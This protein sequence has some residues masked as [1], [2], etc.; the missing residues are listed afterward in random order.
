VAIHD[1]DPQQQFVS[2]DKLPDPR[3]DQEKTNSLLSSYNHDSPDIAYAERLAEELVNLSGA[4]ITVYQRTQNEGNKDE[5]WDEDADPTYR[6]GK[7]I[8][9]FFEPAPADI[10]LTR[11]GVDIQNQTTVH[12]SRANIFQTFGKRMISEGDVLIV[13]HN[14]MSAAQIPDIREGVHN[15]VDRYRVIKASDSGNFKYRWL[16]WSALI[17]NITG[18]QTIDVSFRTEKS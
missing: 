13:P 2:I 16:Y 11:Y 18:D 9:G 7:K 5:V 1:F 3:L 14:T 10:Q 4:W 12:F 8:K 15:R 6:N 17:E